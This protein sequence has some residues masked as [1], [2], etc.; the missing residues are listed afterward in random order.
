MRSMTLTLLVL[1]LSVLSV[2]IPRDKRP[3]SEDLFVV[4]AVPA[5]YP[6]IAA[7]AEESGTVMVEVT[8]RPD[9]SVSEAKAIDGHKLFRLSAEKSGHMWVFN[10]IANLKAS[11]SAHLTFSFRL[12]E[13]KLATPEELLPVFMPP[14]GVETRGT[15]PTYVF[16]KSVV[17]PDPKPRRETKRT[18]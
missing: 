16:H 15:T 7:V 18:P 6:K 4:R 9:G 12:I 14:F 8:I 10:P 17:A 13:K 2:A 1:A 11:R 3:Y 5:I